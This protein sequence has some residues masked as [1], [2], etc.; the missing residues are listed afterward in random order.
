MYGLFVDDERNPP[1]TPGVIWS[2]ARTF[3]AA[4]FMLERDDY[5]IVS[6]DHDLACFYGNKEMTGR[7]VLNWLIMNK[8]D[9]KAVP[10]TI[11]VHSA[12]PVGVATMEADIK[13]HWG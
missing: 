5:S 1:H 9:G 6:L 8:L 4:I 13:Q 11:R 12:N 10:G 3:H 7:D 2:I